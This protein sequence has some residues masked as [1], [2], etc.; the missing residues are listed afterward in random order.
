MHEKL[1]SKID[2]IRKEWGEEFIE[3]EYHDDFA[4][5]EETVIEEERWVNRIRKVLRYEPTDVFIEIIFDRDV[6]EGESASD[7]NTS[8]HFVTPREVTTTVYDRVESK[9]AA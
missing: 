7:L 1:E 5:M 6:A 9:P 8:W 4:L 2:A 3:L